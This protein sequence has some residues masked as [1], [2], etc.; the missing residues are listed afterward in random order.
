MLPH[1]IALSC[2]LSGGATGAGCAGQ[3]LGPPL[4]GYAAELTGSFEG[5]LRAAALFPLACA[6][7]AALFLRTPAALGAQAARD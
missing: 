4:I 5:P 3:P 7:L 6:V 1:D 2:R